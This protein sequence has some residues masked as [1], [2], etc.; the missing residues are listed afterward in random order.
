MRIHSVLILGG[1]LVGGGLI[2]QDGLSALPA[3]GEAELTAKIQRSP[4]WILPSEQATQIATG[5]RFSEGQGAEF[6]ADI[7]GEALLI[8]ADGD[9]TLETRTAIRGEA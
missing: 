7:D 1:T 4:K 2:A 5:F 3:R 6:K 9:G 8:D